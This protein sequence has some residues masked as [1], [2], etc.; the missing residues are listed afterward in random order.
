M[1]HFTQQI[2]ADGLG[3]GFSTRKSKVSYY[4]DEEFSVYQVSP[5]HPMKPFRVKMT[6]SLIRSYGL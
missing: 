3:G 1:S 2:T 4:F 6:D 5:S